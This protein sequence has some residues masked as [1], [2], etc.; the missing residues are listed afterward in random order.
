MTPAALDALSDINEL[1]QVSQRLIAARDAEIARKSTRI[2]HLE[3]LLNTLR[4]QRY[5]ARSEQFNA[6]QQGLWDA[7]LGED[8]AATTAAVE[9]IAP[10]RE[11]E[12]A[13]PKRQPLPETLPRVE[14]RIEPASC[15]CGACGGALHT[16]GEEVSEK[17][18]IKPVEF[19]VR[20]IIRPKLACRACVI[21]TRKPRVSASKMRTFCMSPS[22][23]SAATFTL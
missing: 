5:G 17:L 22:G 3:L 12:R 1:R 23:D 16:I 18:D 20:R 15:T 14:E 4:R 6:E 13:Q 10:P 9:Q 2:E 11:R 21:D 19:F 8:V 7:A